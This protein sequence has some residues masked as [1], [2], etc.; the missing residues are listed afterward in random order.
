MCNF[1]PLITIL[2]PAM[3]Q[4]L[5][6]HEKFRFPELVNLEVIMDFVINIICV[7][8]EKSVRLF[9]ANTLNA[10]WW[11]L[12]SFIFPSQTFLGEMQLFF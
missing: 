8:E 7:S 2:F 1:N 6:V 12:K 9:I 5:K 11:D 3:K 4:M 10:S